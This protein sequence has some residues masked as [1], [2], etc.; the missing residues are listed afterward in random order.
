MTGS[1]LV[2][3]LIQRL[4][5]ATCRGRKVSGNKAAVDAVIEALNLDGS[6]PVAVM[7]QDVARSFLQGGSIASDRKKYDIY[8]EATKLVRTHACYAIFAMPLIARQPLKH[9]E[10]LCCVSYGRVNSACKVRNV[11]YAAVSGGHWPGHFP[12]YMPAERKH[13]TA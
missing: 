8:M 4:S 10:S 13:R 5:C 9:I 11:S 6:N 3:A 1:R 2:A 12:G 7:T